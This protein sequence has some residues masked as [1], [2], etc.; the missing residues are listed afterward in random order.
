MDKKFYFDLDKDGIIDYFKEE[1]DETAQLEFKRGDADLNKLYKE[2]AAFAN[3]DGGILIYGSPKEEEEKIK[4][5]AKRR[6]CKGDIIP[7]KLTKSEDDILSSI[8]SNITPAPVG[9]SIK[10]IKLDEGC[11]YIFHVPKSNNKPHQCNGAYYIRINTMSLAAEH[12]T[13][14]MMFKQ[15]QEVDLNVKVIH[16]ESSTKGLSTI[17]L[18]LTNKTRIPAQKFEFY[19]S[20]IGEVEQM[21]KKDEHKQFL[22]GSESLNSG[23]SRLSIHMSLNEAVIDKI[24]TWYSFHDILISTDYCYLDVTYWAEGVPSKNDIY[25]IYKDFSKPIEV[26]YPN[27][28]EAKEHNKWQW[29]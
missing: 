12:G 9:I 20:I 16:N 27:T 18:D 19:F 8:H 15:V 14:E 26:V 11:V 25:K 3:T 10:R 5:D 13:V 4:G 23:Y 22:L 29:G 21:G 7:S 24:T 28:Q 1:R 2:I 6:F 17:R